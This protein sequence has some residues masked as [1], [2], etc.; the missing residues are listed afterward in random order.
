MP[1]LDP[2]PVQM[3]MSQVLNLSTRPTTT[4]YTV[5]TKLFFLSASSIEYG[6]S[7]SL[8]QRAAL[9]HDGGAVVQ[10]CI[11]NSARKRRALLLLQLKVAWTE[12]MSWN[13]LRFLR[14]YFCCLRFVCHIRAKSLCQEPNMHCAAAPSIRVTRKLFDTFAKLY[15][16]QYKFFSKDSFYKK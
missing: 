16:K 3:Q 8:L 7:Y 12:C 10:L 9:I 14:Y 1:D 5:Q 15:C 4:A 11:K 13:F 6:R 2:I